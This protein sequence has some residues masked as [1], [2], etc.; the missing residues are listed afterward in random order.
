MTNTKMPTLWVG[1]DG[2][3]HHCEPI[4]APHKLVPRGDCNYIDW[5]VYFE[6]LLV[7]PVWFMIFCWLTLVNIT[8]KESHD[9]STT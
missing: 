5:W 4:Q 7:V 6:I 8:R 1:F 2:R 3:S 9:R